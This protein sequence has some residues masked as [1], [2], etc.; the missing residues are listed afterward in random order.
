MPIAERPK[1]TRVGSMA[2][3]PISAPLGDRG[4]SVTAA[5]SNAALLALHVE[6]P[7]RPFAITARVR[8]GA[9]E[10][11]VL[12]LDE[13]HRYV[14]GEWALTRLVRTAN[15]ARIVTER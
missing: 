2:G 7:S 8:I 10:A 6:D 4:V 5:K 11:A 3:R 1:D 15:K 12:R 9:P 13:V 14:A